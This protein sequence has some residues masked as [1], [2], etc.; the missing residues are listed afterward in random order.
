M[1]RNL[2]EAQ[3]QHLNT[4]LLIVIN[5]DIKELFIWVNLMESFIDL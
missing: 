2:K 3:T 4:H 5:T 1:L